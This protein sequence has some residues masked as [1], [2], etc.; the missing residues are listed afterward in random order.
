MT[1]TAKHPLPHTAP[2][3]FTTFKL[4]KGAQTY[5]FMVYTM[6][7]ERWAEAFAAERGTYGTSTGTSEHLSIAKARDLWKKLLLLGWK[8]AK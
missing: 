4:T 1:Y 6:G 8:P 5:T 7:S 2:K 3:T